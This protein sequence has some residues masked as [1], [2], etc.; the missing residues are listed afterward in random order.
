MATQRKLMTAEEFA[1]LPDDGM[2]HELVRGE[3]TT[4][5]PAR[6][7]HGYIAME[8]AFTLDTFIRQHR[9]GRS[10]AAE[11]GFWIES[12]PDTVRAPDFAFLSFERLPGPSPEHWPEGLVPDLVVEVVSPSDSARAVREKMEQWVR[13]GVRLGIVA[14]PRTQS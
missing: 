13:S 4:S 12:D 1:C 10:F 8:I 3:V 7:P 9:L 14:H 5:P 2:R 11:T 6:P